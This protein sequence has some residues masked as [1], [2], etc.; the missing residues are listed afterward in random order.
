MESGPA[1]IPSEPE[2]ATRWFRERYD[3]A[4]NQIIEFFGADF[5]TLTGRD[6]AD[7]GCG[8]GIIDLGV[9]RRT[10]PRELVG[11]D[12]VPVDSELLSS[13]AEANG[14]PPDLP[15]ALKFRTAPAE[16][17]DAEDAS[18]DLAFSWSAFHHFQDPGRAVAEL[19]RVLRPGGGLMIQVYPFYDS[20]HGSLLE[21]WYPDGFAQLLEPPEAIARTV[22]ADPGPD[23][24]WAEHLLESFAGLNRLGLDELGALLRTGGFRITR[25]EVIG[26][27]A[28]IP[29]EL[30][31]RPLSKLAVGGV[32]LLA[33]RL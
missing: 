3:L 33:V 22:R 23:P 27:H 16:Q 6:V 11:F 12:R 31:G 9:F 14:E 20:P 13:L 21:A 2:Q 7:V 19:H 10:S 1:R 30:S 32:K 18:F 26:E 15:D 8:D 5:H 25:A 29:P 28:R 24:E 4:A 17:L